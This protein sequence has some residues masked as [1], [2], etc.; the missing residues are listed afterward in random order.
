VGSNPISHPNK[1]ALS[2]LGVTHSSAELSQIGKIHSSAERFMYLV[3]CSRWRAAFRG[4]RDDECALAFRPSRVTP[5]RR[6]P[7][8]FGT[9]NQ[10]AAQA[11]R[12]RTSVAEAMRSSRPVARRTPWTL[13]RALR[14]RSRMRHR[15]RTSAQM[16]SAY[17]DR[18]RGLPPLCRHSEARS[19]RRKADLGTALASELAGP[20]QSTESSVG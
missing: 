1:H 10:P 20:D 14:C 17:S 6:T 8:P 12:T 18:E 16:P 19:E 3:E 7:I 4:K 5:T 11:I 9:P 15:R 13:A 2:R